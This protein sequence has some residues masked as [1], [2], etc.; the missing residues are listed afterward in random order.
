VVGTAYLLAHLSAIYSTP[1]PTSIEATATA[2]EL[3]KSFSGIL[4]HTGD[5]F[6]HT[7]D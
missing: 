6:A 7:S 2:M 3:N 4:P 5:I 1:K